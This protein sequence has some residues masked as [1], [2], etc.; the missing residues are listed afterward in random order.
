MA[1]SYEEA[2][3]NLKSKLEK[4][5]S[6]NNPIFWQAVLKEDNRQHLP[7]VMKIVDAA[8]AQNEELAA[9]RQD[10][11]DT[12][13]ANVVERRSQNAP[14]PVAGFISSA[15]RYPKSP[16]EQATLQVDSDIAK[17]KRQRAEQVRKQVNEV[18]KTGE[19]HAKLRID[20]ALI[21]QEKARLIQ[22][23][24]Q[25]IDE[26]STAK[27]QLHELKTKHRAQ[28]IELARNRGEVNPEQ[29]VSEAF[30]ASTQLIEGREK[31][32]LS[33]LFQIYGHKYTQ[34]HERAA[35]EKL[36][37]EHESNQSQSSEQG[38]KHTRARTHEQE[39]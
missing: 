16:L 8:Q 15:L 7:H 13:V 12:E 36:I 35:A 23:A 9:K 6:L 37:Q 25:A 4:E 32:Q 1:Y 5:F 11:I 34:G 3:K 10:M 39:Q 29:T 14:A 21:A 28:M 26:A 2:M 17:E 22:G 38:Q 30:Q 18:L 19:Q 24:R 33:A 27:L 20:P 31:N